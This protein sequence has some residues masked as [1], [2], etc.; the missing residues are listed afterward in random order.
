MRAM[1]QE[2]QKAVV[3]LWQDDHFKSVTTQSIEF[4]DVPDA[5]TAMSRRETIGRVVVQVG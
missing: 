3:Q 5:L 2:T 1:E 4:A